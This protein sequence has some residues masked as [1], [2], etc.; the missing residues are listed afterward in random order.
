MLQYQI[1]RQPKDYI[2]R[3]PFS[4]M[5]QCLDHK[6]VVLFQLQNCMLS[7]LRGGRL[8]QNNCNTRLQISFKGVWS[9]RVYKAKVKSSPKSIRFSIAAPTASCS[10]SGQ[11]EMGKK[12]RSEHTWGP[13]AI[14]QTAVLFQRSLMAISAGLVSFTN[15]ID[16][17]LCCNT[18]SE[19][20]GT[21]L[22]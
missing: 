8:P 13:F 18:A 9:S 5:Y 11:T 19:W 12:G 6:A 22:K 3:I 4:D 16:I 21:A 17:C 1:R 15:G 20:R 14:R 7:Q 10:W 2:S